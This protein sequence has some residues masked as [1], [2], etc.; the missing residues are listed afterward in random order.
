MTLRV[1]VHL[2]QRQA[3]A[4]LL[5]RDV[6][7][8]TRTRHSQALS[9]PSFTSFLSCHCLSPLEVLSLAGCDDEHMSQSLWKEGKAWPFSFLP[10]IT[11]AQRQSSTAAD[12][13]D[14]TP[15]HLDQFPFVMISQQCRARSIA[16]NRSLI[17]SPN[18]KQHQ[19]IGDKITSRT[20]CYT[21]PSDF[22]CRPGVLQC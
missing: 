19:S 7:G 12:N 13:L 2:K 10:F 5:Y 14:Q 16:R 6:W 4:P 22:N 8:T 11:T 18:I 21:N 9:T 3:L 1:H 17:N 15:S 20:N